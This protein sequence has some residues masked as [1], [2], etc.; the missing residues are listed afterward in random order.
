MSDFTSDALVA[1][2]QWIDQSDNYRNCDPETVLWRRVTKVASEAGEVI[3]ALAGYV[4]ENPRKGVTH[5]KDELVG[6]LLDSAVA[7]LGAVEH[8]TGNSGLAL[9]LLDDKI[10]AVATRAGLVT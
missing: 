8:L 9:A 4:G 3:D 5:T 2:S 7:A 1:L 6:E 10:V